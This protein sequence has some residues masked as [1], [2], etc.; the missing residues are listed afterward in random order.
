MIKYNKELL[1]NAI[2]ESDKFT[3]SQKAL[4]VLIIELS[5]DSVMNMS[6]KINIS[7]KSIVEMTGFSQTIICKNLNDLEKLNYI[8]REKSPKTKVGYIQLITASFQ[9]IIDFLVKK[10][11]ISLRKYKNK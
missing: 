5:E 10:Q 4:L 9:P 11:Q 1:I 8:R 2:N 6:I 3:K 7:I